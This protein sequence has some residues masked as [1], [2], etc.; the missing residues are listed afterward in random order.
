MDYDHFHFWGKHLLWW[1]IW[2]V[3]LFWL[4]ATPYIIPG[5]NAKKDAPIDILKKR[6][7]SREINKQEFE[8]KKKVIKGKTN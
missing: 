3:L 2:V 7:Y 4:F 8:R 5:Q 6:F 1:F